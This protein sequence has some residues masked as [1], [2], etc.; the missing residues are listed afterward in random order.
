MSIAEAIKTKR[1]VEIHGGIYRG[2]SVSGVF[3]FIEFKNDP[4]RGPI[5]RIEREGQ[6]PWISLSNGTYKIIEPG[7]KLL[8]DSPSDAITVDTKLNGPVVVQNSGKMTEAEV[9]FLIKERFDVMMSLVHTLCVSRMTSLIITGAPGIGKTFNI[10]E[11]L[12]KRELNQGFHWSTV[13]GKCTPFGLYTALYETRNPGSVLVLDDVEV[14]DNDDSLNILKKALDSS[15]VRTIDWRSAS[16]QLDEFGVPDKFEYHGKV[17]FLTNVNPHREI[18]R[19]S[20]LA[21]HLL[22]LMDR[23]TLLD[24]LIHDV[25]TIMLHVRRVTRTTNMLVNRGLTPEQQEDALTWLSL[26]ATKLLQLSLRTPLRIGEYMLHDPEWE[27]TCRHT[28]WKPI[29]LNW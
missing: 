4:T 1:M 28:L 19:G 22:A 20:R 23:S 9:D 14:W 24:L 17:I 10:T 5:V 7:E 15:E 25:R 13:G 8:I 6:F 11:Y 3:P 21:V 2:N 26:H 27:K 29:A 18:S 12:T 16:R